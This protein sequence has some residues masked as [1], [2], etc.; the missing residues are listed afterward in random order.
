MNNAE[1]LKSSDFDLEDDV[2]V[3]DAEMKWTYVHT[4]E[5]QCGPYYFCKK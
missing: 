5:S 4:H 1:Q 3:V 2:Y